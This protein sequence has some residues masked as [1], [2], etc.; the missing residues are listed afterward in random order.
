VIVSDISKLNVT[1]EIGSLGL[2]V[3]LSE[4]LIHTIKS[5]LTDIELANTLDIATVSTKVSWDILSQVVEGL[6]DVVD[7]FRLGESLLWLF[8]SALL[9]DEIAGISRLIGNGVRAVVVEAQLKAL[10]GCP[11]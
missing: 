5:C 7:E 4:D 1:K 6:S 9:Y 11:L 2:K 10:I 3:P 8:G